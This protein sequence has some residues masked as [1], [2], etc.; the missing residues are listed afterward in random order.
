MQG[1]LLGR[2]HT[3]L[4]LQQNK[5]QQI[6]HGG[7]IPATIILSNPIKWSLR[8]AIISL[9][10][11]LMRASAPSLYER[12]S[13]GCRLRNGR[14]SCAGLCHLT[15]V[16]VFESVTEGAVLSVAVRGK[17]ILLGSYKS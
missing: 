15:V 2:T 9:H 5:S 11:F 4:S 1:W 8:N 10:S 12:Q 14:H 7:L 17:N 6:V 3:T 13:K 16:F